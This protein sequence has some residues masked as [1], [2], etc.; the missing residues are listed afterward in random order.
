MRQARRR[1]AAAGLAAIALFCWPRGAAAQ[2]ERD[3]PVPP[4]AAAAPTVFTRLAQAGTA[5]DHP[6]ADYLLA[7]DQ[8]LTRVTDTG[9]AYVDL[10][11][12]Y[13]ILT[14]DGVRE[15]SA[16]EWGYDPRSSFVEVAEVNVVRDGRRI[17]VPVSGILDLPAPQS[18][19][20]WADRIK[21]LQLP[22]L[23]VGD[24]IEVV[25]MRKGYNYALL[26][27][28]PAGGAPGGAASAPAGASPAPAGEPSR[29]PGALQRI[30]AAGD[31]RY[32]PPMRGEYFDIVLMQADVP[33]VEKRYTLILP[34]SKRLIS[35]SYN[36]PVYS[37]TSYSPDSTEYTW[38]VQDMPALPREPR[39]AEEPDVAPKVVLTTAANWQ[40]KSKWFFDV[41]KNQFEVTDDIRRHVDGVL[42]RAGLTRQSD[43]MR[44]ATAVNHWVAQNIRYSGQTMGQGEGFTLHPSGPLFEYRSGVCKDIA[45]MSIT[46]LRAAGLHTYPAMT[47]AGSRIEDIPADQFNHC[48]VAWER[49]PG[50][51]VMIDPTWVPYN[52]DLWSKLETEQQYLIGHPDGVGLKEIRYSP[53][54]ESPLTVTHD[55]DLG[56]DGTLT[57]TLRIEGRGATDSRL[58]RLVVRSRKRALEDAVAEILGQVGPAVRITQLTHRAV[59]DFTGDMWLAV[60]YEMPRFAMRAGDALEFSPPAARAVKDHPLLF[61]AGS[62]NW[63][64]TRKTDVFLYYTQRLDINETVRL[65]AGYRL[66]E[67]PKLE[68]VA[69]TYATFQGAVAQTGR[70]LS[71]RARA[72]VRRRQIPPAGY[73]G[74]RKALEALDAYAAAP[75][76]VAKGGAR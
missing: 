40:A 1:A 11:Q 7:L 21:E 22:R 31:D 29:V 8:T 9:I 68:A 56:E 44:I 5:A 46:L 32:V 28:A 63:P 15:K 55:A 57:G 26:G 59:D 34:Q 24:G 20:Y 43:P 64:K 16:L 18:M 30:R 69:D 36:G 66:V 71:L 65:P 61:A 39:Q 52:N 62:V 72:E 70:A 3:R 60:K 37:R 74:F 67:P 47:M 75:L 42:A 4:G 73:D 51:F 12:V 53:P 17:P 6:G 27:A 2:L 76:R 41:N 23:R 13:K 48:V 38:W 50:D 14:E 45:S 33:I 54:S 49:S 35:Q 10:Y 58:R 19:I 25:A